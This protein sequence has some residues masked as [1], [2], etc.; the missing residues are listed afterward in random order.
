M[1][2]S[3]IM[4]PLQTQSSMVCCEEILCKGIL[5][6]SSGDSI[7]RC[8]D[9]AEIST[10][11]VVDQCAANCLKEAVLSF[12]AMRSKSRSQVCALTSPSVDHFQFFDLFSAR[13]FNASKLASLWNCSAAHELHLRDRKSS[14]SKADNPPPFQLY[15]LFEFLLLLSYR[16]T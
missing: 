6:H 2:G 8:I 11:V 7:R 14:F 10:P 3:V 16:H 1:S 15:K 12:T 9:E 4:N 13:R 5:A